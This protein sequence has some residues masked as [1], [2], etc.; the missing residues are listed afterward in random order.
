MCD[1]CVSQGYNRYYTV[2]D[3]LRW[4]VIKITIKYFGYLYNN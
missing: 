3:W 4:E 2:A 1:Y